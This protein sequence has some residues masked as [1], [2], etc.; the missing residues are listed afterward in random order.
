MPKTPYLTS[1]LMLLILASGHNATAETAREACI[2]KVQNTEKYAYHGKAGIER[3]IKELCGEEVQAAPQ[4][5]QDN[6]SEV[7]S[8]M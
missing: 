8:A 3:G 1:T 6:A 4:P 2:R 5:G 7:P